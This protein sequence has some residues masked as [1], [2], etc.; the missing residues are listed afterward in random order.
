MDDSSAS[1]G[2]TFSLHT[3]N[4]ASFNASSGTNSTGSISIAAK[5]AATTSGVSFNMAKAS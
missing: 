2:S 4:S 5:S 1:G 3:S